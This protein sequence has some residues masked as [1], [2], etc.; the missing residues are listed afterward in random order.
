MQYFPTLTLKLQHLFLPCDQPL[1]QLYK[2]SSLQIDISA[3]R[4]VAHLSSSLCH[5]IGFDFV[6]LWE[7]KS[8]ICNI[9]FLLYFRL[10]FYIL[11]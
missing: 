9:S 1:I 7:R 2:Y 4:Q 3:C 6:D 11:I 10:S 8:I 5:V